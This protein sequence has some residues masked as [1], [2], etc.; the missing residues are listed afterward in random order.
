MD[1]VTIDAT[2]LA[3]ALRC[4]VVGDWVELMGHSVTVDDL[5]IASNTVSYELLTGLGARLERVIT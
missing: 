5:A 4:P 2:L 3:Q 1:L